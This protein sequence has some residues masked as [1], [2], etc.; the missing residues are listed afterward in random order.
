M[1][2][3]GVDL[4]GSEEILLQEGLQ[5]NAAHLASAQN[6]DAYVGNLRRCF[7]GLN[8]Y[9]RHFFPCLG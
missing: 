3:R 4:I 1:S 7:G 9:I 6:G 5:Q 2:H 8:S